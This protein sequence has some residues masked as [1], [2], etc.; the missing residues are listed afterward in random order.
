MKIFV[1]SIFAMLLF[2]CNTKQETDNTQTHDTT[3][4][5]AR[6]D[7]IS[8]IRNVVDPT[9]VASYSKKIPDDLNDWKFAVN[10]YETRETFHYLMKVQ[11]EELKVTDTLKI[12]NFGIAPKIEIHPGPDDYSCI[13]GFLDKDKKFLE[14]K[15]VTAAG[16]DLKIKVLHH[17]AVTTY[18]E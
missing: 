17:Y 6:A 16:G 18:S 11:Y 7:T 4:T 8:T 1:A 13:V 9:A 3:K 15:L 10:V 14:Y 2:A 5:I 12:P